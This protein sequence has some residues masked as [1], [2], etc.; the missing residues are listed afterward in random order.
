MNFKWLVSR[1]LR[2]QLVKHKHL[3][4]IQKHVNT[5]SK[6]DWMCLLV[7]DVIKSLDHNIINR[8]TDISLYSMIDRCNTFRYRISSDDNQLK[9]W[10]FVIMIG[11]NYGFHMCVSV[12]S[13][14]N[15]YKVKTPISLIVSLRFIECTQCD[16]FVK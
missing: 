16:D 6:W 7:F 5:S 10:C 1:G 9:C 11:F 14:S 12:L 4:C 2:K 3:K 8:H 15:V 13:A